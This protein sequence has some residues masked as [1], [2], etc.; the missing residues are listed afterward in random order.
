MIASV[1]N[2][3][4]IVAGGLI[5]LLFGGRI[6]KRFG[7][8]IFSALGLCVL[9]I[10]IMSATATKHMLHVII[11]IV[12]GAI[13]G[14]ALRIEDRLKGLGDFL[15]ARFAK[16]GEA[17]RF[18]KAFVTT[19]LLYCV[20]SMAI[21]GSLEAGINGNYEIIYSKSIMDGVSSITFAAGMGVGVL[22]SS[23]PVLVYQGAIT[24][25]ASFLAPHLN[26]MIVGEMSAIGGL[27]LIAM[28]LDMLKVCK[29]RYANLIPAII[30]PIGYFPLLDALLRLIHTFY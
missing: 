23:L 13:I 28:A 6:Q 15:S 2:A 21:M 17:G 19:S 1:V 24:L 9:V 8:L 12:I 16:E 26:E 22:F 25:L 3:S 27:L 7:E 14:E 29:I 20:G 30:L 11:Q 4:V 5:G 18:T 10:G